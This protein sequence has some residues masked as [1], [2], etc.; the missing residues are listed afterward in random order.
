MSD[1]AIRVESLSKRYRLGER[2]AYKALRDVLAAA[3]AAP[4]R[5]LKAVRHG[6]QPAAPSGDG[7]FWALQRLND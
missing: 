3:A 7:A 1:I 2:E 5:R 6:A 4:F